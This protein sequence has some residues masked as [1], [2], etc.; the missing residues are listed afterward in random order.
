[1][2]LILFLLTSLFQFSARESTV[3]Q[4]MV[5]SR[6]LNWNKVVNWNDMKEHI[7]FQIGTLS[8]H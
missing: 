5:D 2:P 7:P 8:V 1:M 6:A 4:V 3:I